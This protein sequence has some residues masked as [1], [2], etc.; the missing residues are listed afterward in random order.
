MTVLDVMRSLASSAISA[1]ILGGKDFC[2]WFFLEDQ[3]CKRQYWN[4][5]QSRNH[6]LLVLEDVV[7]RFG[8]EA[9]ASY[10]PVE[11]STGWM[12][13]GGGNSLIRGR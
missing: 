4:I 7:F 1:I 6:P 5:L 10:L 3:N 12:A 8:M 9:A 2:R 13:S 11:G